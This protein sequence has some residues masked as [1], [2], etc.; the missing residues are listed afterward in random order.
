MEMD[1]GMPPLRINDRPEP[2]D[3]YRLLARELLELADAWKKARWWERWAVANAIA[4][5]V[6]YRSGEL[7]S[8]LIYHKMG[9]QA[10]NKQC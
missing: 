2:L 10:L 6:W 5:K 4:C 8:A 1:D 7:Q 9:M 3:E